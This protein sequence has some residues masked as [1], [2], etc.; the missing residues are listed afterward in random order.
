M[1]KLTSLPGKVER[2]KDEFNLYGVKYDCTA[3]NIEVKT[4]VATAY[5]IPNKNN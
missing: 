4:K 2:E 3:K 1:A 5:E